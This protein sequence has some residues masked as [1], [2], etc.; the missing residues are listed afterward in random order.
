MKKIIFLLTATA[1]FLTACSQGINSLEDGESILTINLNSAFVSD[2]GIATKAPVPDNNIN[3]LEI[4]IFRKSI[5]SDEGILDTY[6]HFAANEINDL[7]EIKVK[8]TVGD[9]YIYVIA[10]AHDTTNF[11]GISNLED[12]KRLE[13]YLYHERKNDFLMTGHTEETLGINTNISI[14]LER[15]VSKIILKSITTKFAG[16]PYQGCC[17]KNPKAYLINIKGSKLI[18]DGNKPRM[19]DIILN[20]GGKIDEDISS[21]QD[22]NLFYKDFPSSINDT[23]FNEE[24]I[25]YSYSN[26]ISE[27]NV[28]DKFTR[29]V[30]EGE[31]NGITYYYPININQDDFGH[32]EL[33]SHYGIKRNH[34]YSISLT[35][36]RPGSMNPDE[37]IVFGTISMGIT[38]SDWNVM[39]D[40]EIQL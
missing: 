18:Y 13:H 24:I 9:K 7:S 28:N 27:E 19:G 26:E 30:I 4:L 6:E 10:N 1:F 8:S 14:N 17:L 40:A 5:G 15:M 12:F 32:N 29:L 39:P 35:I 16:T 34:A 36:H 33:I 11:S 21:C 38:C 22:K 3:S 25:L 20:R 2:S 31:I 37:P 23:G